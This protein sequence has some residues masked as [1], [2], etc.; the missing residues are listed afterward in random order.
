MLTLLLSTA[1]GATLPSGEPL[2]NAAALHLS[3]GGL[4]NLGTALEGVLPSSID[5]ALI[6]GEFECDSSGDPLAYSISNLSLGIQN[7][8]VSIDTSSGSLLVTIDLELTASADSVTFTGDCT[9]LLSDL[10]QDC[11]M[12]ISSSDPIKVQLILDIGMELTDEGAVDATVNE[13]SYAFDPIPNPLN[14]CAIAT[15]FDA[16]LALNPELFNDL[17]ATF[18]DPTL[19]DIGPQIETALEDAFGSLQIATE[20][21]LGASTVSLELYPSEL[22]IDDDGLF[23]GFGSV[24][25]ID[26]MGD[27]ADF[28][29]GSPMSSEGWPATGETA[30]DEGGLPYD[31]AILLNKDFMDSVLWHVWAS[32]MLCANVADLAD[33]PLDTDFLGNLYG[34][35]FQELFPE[36]QSVELT[37]E[38]PSQPT[39]RFS[40]DYPI[41]VDIADLGLNTASTLDARM[42]RVCAV[43]IDGSIALD[44]GLTATELAP[45]IVV[46]PSTFIYSDAY[47]E[48]L[49]PGYSEGVA[50][51]LSTVLTSFLPDDLLPVVT[52]PTWQGI[53][54]KDVV[55]Q[56]TDDGQW[57]G[58]FITLNTED[59]TPLEISGCGG[60]AGGDTGG[61]T[62]D[63]LGCSDTTSGCSDSGCSGGSGCA[64]GGLAQGR[65]AMIGALLALLI[66]RRR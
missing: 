2:D 54:V 24:T 64:T 52:L 17:I 13:V 28:G 56:P 36:P 55:W 58:G 53:G 47:S 30:W 61:S 63:I 23:L 60:C 9:S 1:L 48:L 62:T 51:L 5:E 59:V 39:T 65:L 26:T 45:E 42:T 18:L 50:S 14:D 6:E 15:V 22:K 31:A 46:D 3:E 16:L 44:V 38:A 12:E 11:G 8:D 33:L 32:G 43:G 41:Y 34:E 66:R 35:S 7:Q 25:A 19:A 40:D 20:L 4:D 49:D 57:Q 27:C 37:L 21:P 10:E 29:D